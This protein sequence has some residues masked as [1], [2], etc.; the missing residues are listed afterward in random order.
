LEQRW[1]EPPLYPED[2][3]QRRSAL[4]LEDLFDEELGPASR[5]LFL[6]HTLPDP[7]LMLGAFV[8]DLS[9]VRR[10]AARAMF[11]RIR[12]QVIRGF[13]ITHDTVA[14]AFDTLTRVGAHIRTQLAE[15]DYLVGDA[16]S[17]A[18]LT[19]AALLSPPVAPAQ[20]P[21]PQPQRGHPRLAP[22][23]ETLRESGVLEW[24][25]EMYAR[26]RGRS[27]EIRV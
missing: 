15:G 27:A 13:G 12:R 26:H 1:P 19:A 17:V 6:A 16:F 11:P 22:V 24:V 2:P 18:D 7:R 23:R 4:E 21:Y 20:F 14:A 8:P 3:V 9:G 10:L 5:L 25:H